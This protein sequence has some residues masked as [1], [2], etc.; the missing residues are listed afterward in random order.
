LAY[1]TSRYS[2]RSSDEA[3]FVNY[4]DT[5]RAAAWEESPMKWYYADGGRQVGPVEESALD[6]LVRAGSVRDD[7]LVWHEGMTNWQL[8]GAGGGPG[9]APLAS[10]LGRPYGAAADRHRR[11][12]RSLFRLQPRRHNWQAGPW[13]EDHP[14]GWLTGAGRVGCRPLF[15]PVDQRHHLVHRLH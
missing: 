4:P 3:F 15:W 1:N 13:P 8:H 14:R 10:R 5:A 11:S 12:V 6:N 2:K 9:G 7:T